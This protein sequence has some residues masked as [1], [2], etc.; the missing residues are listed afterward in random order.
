MIGNSLPEDLSIRG[1]I[2]LFQSVAPLSTLWVLGRSL[3]FFPRIS[4]LLDV[5]AAV[6]C[7]F[8]FLVYL[9]I[10]AAYQRPAVH[11]PAY[12]AAERERLLRR[13]LDSVPDGDK[14]LSE[15]FQNADIDS[16]KEENLKEYLAWAFFNCSLESVTDLADVKDLDRYVR[17]VEEHQASNGR[18]I[19]PG[20]SDVRGMRLTLDP[21]RMQARPLTWYL[22]LFLVDTLTFLRLRA[23]GFT[24]HHPRSPY[25]LPAVFPPRLHALHPTTQPSPSP[26][27]S[28]YFR[29]HTARTHLPIVFLHGIG[30]G[31][32]TYIPLL[33]AL[34]AHRP[35][36][37]QI[38]ILAIELLQVSFRL[39]PPIPPAARL[40]HD[41]RALMTAHHLPHALLLSHSY[42]SILTAHLLKSPATPPALFPA[43]VLIDPVSLLVHHASVAHNFVYRAPRSAPQR[44]LAYFA[45]RDPGVARTLSRAFFW[46]ENT[47]WRDELLRPGAAVSV[48]L[49]GRD[50]IVDTPAVAAYLSQGRFEGTFLLLLLLQTDPSNTPQAPPTPATSSSGTRAARRRTQAARASRQSQ[51]TPTHRPRT[52]ACS[53]STRRTTRMCASG[54]GGGARWCRRFCGGARWARRRW[55]VGSEA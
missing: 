6:E 45:S 31:L 32:H 46:A 13:V 18:K 26:I 41:I 14:F 24:L 17:L 35:A 38:G 22:I 36:D 29:P 2:L 40:A 34:N 15:W 53:G 27:F 50:L 12:P 28:Y 37:S 4:V 5:F 7:A 10:K 33:H 25:G 11:P 54:G 43:A 48:V 21:V 19:P 23:H 3:G 20:R 8:F 42:G 51:Q 49:A 52:C 1:C 44:Q 47:L 16:I 55:R 30:V 9:P 39:T